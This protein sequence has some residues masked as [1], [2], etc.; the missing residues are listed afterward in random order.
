MNKVVPYQFVLNKQDRYNFLL[1]SLRLPISRDIRQYIVTHRFLYKKIFPPDKVFYEELHFDGWL[2]RQEKVYE[3]I[4]EHSF[5]TEKSLCDHRMTVCGIAESYARCGYK[6]LIIIDKKF[7]L[8]DFMNVITN[9]K[10][11]SKFQQISYFPGEIR[12]NNNGLIYVKHT[13]TI[14]Q[15]NIF[16]LFIFYCNPEI[17]LSHMKNVLVINEL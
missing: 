15:H 1:Y 12:Y 9:F 11:S 7:T 3:Q 2:G 14:Y 16:D 4:K 10:K 13:K 6:V 17:I 5:Y 8:S